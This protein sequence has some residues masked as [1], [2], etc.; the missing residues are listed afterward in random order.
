M[1]AGAFFAGR[2]SQGNSWTWDFKRGGAEKQLRRGRKVVHVHTRDTGVVDHVDGR[3]ECADVRWD[4]GT[5]GWTPFREL[6][7]VP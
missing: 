2:G 4:D 5:Q 3:A 7:V 6:E 1:K